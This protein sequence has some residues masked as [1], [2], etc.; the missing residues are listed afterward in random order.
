MS[1]SELSVRRP[2]LM[3][4]VYVLIAVIAAVFISSIDLALYPSVDLPVLSVIVSCNDAGPE[5]IEQQVAKTFE[6]NLSSV[7]NIKNIT[8]RSQEGRCFI[9]LEFE[10][11][12]D[13]DDAKSDVQSVITR[14]TRS[15]PSWAETP[16]V[17]SFDSIMGSSVMSLTLSGPRTVE[18]LQ[19]IAEDTVQPLLERISGVANVDTFGGGEYE[20]AVNVST[21]R[22]NAYG[23]TLA[24]VSAA[25]AGHNVQSTAGSITQGNLDY[26]ITI[27]GRYDT[28]DEISDSVVAV[29][30][31]VA[32]H[33]SDV[34][35]VQREKKSGERESYLNGNQIVTIDISNTSDSNSTTVAKA[36]KAALP[37]ISE[38]IDSDLTLSIE[39][40]STEMISSSMSEVMN[41]A[42]EGVILA[43]AIIFLFLRNVK[44]TIIIALSMPICILITLMIMSISGISV[45][46]LSMAGLILGIGMI[47]DASIIILE[48]TYYYRS[49]G[50]KS[51]V[52]AIKGSQNML[53]A[54]VAST[55][56]T[57]CVFVPLIIYKYQLGMIGIMFQDL[58]ITV[59]ISLACSLFV[60]VTLV[61]ALSGSILKL[62]TRTQKPLKFKP[63]AAIDKAM[64]SFERGMRNG[65]AKVLGYFLDH[66]LLLIVLLVLLLLFS[67]TMFSGIGMSLTPQMT[68]NDE[69]SL[70]LTLD[71]GTNNSVT[72]ASVFAMNEK[73]KETL[74]A[75]SYESITLEV[76]SSNTGSVRIGLPDITEQKYSAKEVQ[77]MLRPL[78]NGNPA[79]TWSIGSG[80]GFST[81]AIDVEI[82]SN[83]ADASKEAASRIE[84]ILNEHVG[85]IQDIS[86][87]ISDG[88]PKVAID[89]DYDKA[90]DYG[91]SVSTISSTLTAALTGLT[92]TEITTFSTDTTYDLVVKVNEEDLSSIDDLSSLMIPT[93][94]GNLPLD[95]FVTFTEGTSP[96]TITRE[97]K[98]RV[99]HITAKA[100]DG[101]SA[102]VA[103]SAVNEALDQYLILPDGV[104]IEQGGEM[105]DFAEYLPIL[106]KVI[107]LALFLV[108]AVM[109]AQF[110]SLLNPF[111]IFATI[112]LL[113]IGV[114]WIHIWT[115]TSFTLF[116]IVGIVALIGVVVNNGIVLVDAINRLIDEE[117]VSVKEACLKSAKG[118]LR[119]ILMT[120]L[121]TILGMI[122]MAFFPG[123]GSEMLQPIALTFVG[124]ITTGAFLTLLLTPVLYSIFNQR[125]EKHYDDPDS[126]K[127]QL[128]EYD[129]A[130]K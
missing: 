79:E 13:L 69:V 59:C 71:P 38:A 15:L 116:S 1:I 122:P 121:T 118:R 91:V 61:P 98:E 64:D 120:T 19:T 27:D 89:I 93:S 87:D 63:L 75:D 45:N 95:T 96:R 29:R 53:T 68:S 124:G 23:V 74:P 36:I 107:I 62:N 56:T 49:K 78:L 76:G 26:S 12:T 77:N 34:A 119:P 80:R 113:M 10:Y 21:N 105:T 65:Y 35:D 100:K 102:S 84:K 111:I 42:V 106:I 127:N 4:M 112:P 82:H 104:K 33:L 3:T 37:S 86:S 43:A 52:A 50:A 67:L 114:I 94:Y 109:A 28:L 39:R 14:V 25:L 117:R 18:E 44:A 97:N 60:A 70:S 24:E 47:V 73:V 8:S 54:I 2:V 40:D 88:A 31:G 7:E 20:Y 129:N 108:Y 128:R 41:S 58:V 126:L 11:G 90:G 22:L 9:I 46:S 130:N 57:L 103:Q 125:K 6:T 85:V 32:I 99:N 83:D 72:R 5:E 115:G 92:A 55:L 30:N 48:N 51:A 66:R 16:Q 110:E 81:S 101:I 123:E 17:I